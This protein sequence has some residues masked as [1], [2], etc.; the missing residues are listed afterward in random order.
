MD[1]CSY[2]TQKY[3]TSRQRGVLPPLNPPLLCPVTIVPVHCSIPFHSSRDT[4][5]YMLSLI[6]S[7]HWLS[8]W[9]ELRLTSVVS[10][11]ILLHVWTINEPHLPYKTGLDVMQSH[12]LRRT[13]FGQYQASSAAL[14]W[15][16][17]GDCYNIMRRMQSGGWPYSNCTATCKI[18][19]DSVE[20]PCFKWDFYTCTNAMNK[21]K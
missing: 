6:V 7:V 3:I 16:G 17:D 20:F 9:F 21:N 4:H 8:G 11:T 15:P 5:H 12:P 18:N 14:G 2:C 13:R 19:E 1:S 10:L